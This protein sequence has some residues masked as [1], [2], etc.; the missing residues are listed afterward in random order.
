MCGSIDEKMG[1]HGNS[2]CVLNYDGASGWIIGEQ[3]KG[4]RAMFTMMNEARLGVGMQGFSQS[5]VSY[6]NAAQYAKERLQ[7]R[8]ISGVKAKDKPADPII[9]HPDVRRT[10][11]TIKSFNEAARA[12]VMWTSLQSDLAHRSPDDKQRQHAFDD[13][14]EQAHVIVGVL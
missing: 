10:L 11:M 13:R 9:V 2:T 3:H 4:M 8:S 14:R 6:Q 5:E 1:I 12:L 7:G